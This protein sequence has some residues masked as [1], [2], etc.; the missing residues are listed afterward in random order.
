MAE[1]SCC[2]AAAIF[3]IMLRRPFA[4]TRFLKG[5]PVVTKAAIVFTVR[6]FKTSPA[7]KSFFPAEGIAIPGELAVRM[8][9]RS[10]GF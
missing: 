8:P 10:E 4:F 1:F 3:K 9:G 5:L 2:P 7:F 6:F